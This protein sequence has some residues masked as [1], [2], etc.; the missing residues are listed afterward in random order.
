MSEE[1]ATRRK[2]VYAGKVIDVGI[3]TVELPNGRTVELEIIRHPGG[4]AAVALDEQ[5][6]VCLVRQYRHAASDWLWELP[7]GRIEPDEDARLTAERELAEEAGVRADDWVDLGPL[8][9]S[10]GVFTEVIHL[11]LARG[12]TI[13]EHAQEDDELMEVHWLPL[14]QALDWCDDGTISDAKTLIGLYRTQGYLKSAL[15]LLSEDPG[16]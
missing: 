10:P 6:R 12:L 7:A 3:D 11:W 16:C 5:E 15:E 4:A 8:H 13:G 14:S 9:S 2:S 1:R